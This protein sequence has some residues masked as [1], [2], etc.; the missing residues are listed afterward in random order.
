MGCWR[1]WAVPRLP[2]RTSFRRMRESWRGVAVVTLG[3]MR[4]RGALILTFSRARE[5]EQ[6]STGASRYSQARLSTTCS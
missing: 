6:D 4:G 3:W 5:K 2:S 1:G